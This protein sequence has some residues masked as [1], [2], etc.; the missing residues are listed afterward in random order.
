MGGS[1]WNKEFSA[2]LDIVF[3]SNH[4]IDNER[5]RIFYLK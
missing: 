4:E 2:Y 1:D 5:A 3:P